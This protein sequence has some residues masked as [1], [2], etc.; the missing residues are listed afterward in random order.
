VNPAQWPSE[1]AAEAQAKQP[2]QAVYDRCAKLGKLDAEGMPPF[3]AARAHRLYKAFFGAA[4]SV[5]AGKH[6]IVVPSASLMQLPF[7][8]LV[9]APPSANADHRAV[10]WLGTM[11][12]VSVLPSVSGLSAL[13]RV[14]K[15]SKASKPF[16][17]VGNPLLTGSKSDAHHQQL[18]QA[19][20][21][22]E[23]CAGPVASAGQPQR[24]VLTPA[25]LQP[26]N[27]FRGP[28]ADIA[29]LT[30]Q[31]PLPETADE[32]CAVAQSVQ[33]GPQDVL[34]GA[35]ATETVLKQMAT[36]AAWRLTAF[37]ISP[38]MASSRAIC[39]VSRSRL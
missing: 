31:V 6:L 8:T 16:L 21:A 27:A 24:A 38:P 17:G 7:A 19:A 26:A 34:L 37:C 4:E 13:R 29:T 32:L 23:S 12:P 2:Q 9:T 25:L 33:A 36:Q 22:R 11:A 35:K 28:L 20:R 5:I 18:A 3:D 10:K 30:A 1:T 15:P 14:A 39:R